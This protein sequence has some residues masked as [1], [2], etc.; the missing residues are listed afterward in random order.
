MLWERKKSGSSKKI[1]KKRNEI[2]T[3]LLTKGWQEDRW[4]NLK[5]ENRRMKFQQIS[6]RMEVK[7][8]YSGWVKLAGGFYSKLEIKE[9]KLDGLS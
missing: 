7:T 4:G 3:F 5:K 8:K 6:L 2:K 1:L 9:D